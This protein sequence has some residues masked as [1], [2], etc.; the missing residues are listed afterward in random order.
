M[1]AYQPSKNVS[2]QCWI[3]PGSTEVHDH[4]LEN[5]RSSFHA[6]IYFYSL[7]PNYYFWSISF[8]P[9][10]TKSNCKV[11]LYLSCN[12]QE[13]NENISLCITDTI[14]IIYNYFIDSKCRLIFIITNIIWREISS[15]DTILLLIYFNCYLNSTLAIF[16]C[17]VKQNNN[18]I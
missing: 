14:I 4:A 15:F 10:A 9:L 5:R 12:E 13:Y 3:Q 2:L 11:D 18:M 8:V 16:A 6:R 7:S 1:T 17:R